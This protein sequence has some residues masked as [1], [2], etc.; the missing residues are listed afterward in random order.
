M[1]NEPIGFQ[2]KHNERKVTLEIEVI[3]NLVVVPVILNKILKM[4]MILDTGVQHT[5]LFDHVVSPLFYIDPHRTVTIMGLGEGE[6]IEANIATLVEMQVANVKAKNKGLLI[7]PPDTEQDVDKYLGIEVHG[8][9]GY[10][11]FKGLPIKIDYG[12]QRLTIYN[13]KFWK[14]KK[15]GYE[16]VPLTI[17][18]GK[19]Y[20]RLNLSDKNES[21]QD[22]EVLVDSGSAL[23]LSIN[24]YAD[25]KLTADEPQAQVSLGSGLIGNLEGS[26]SR[27]KELDIG[28]TTFKNVVAS[29]PN[30]ESSK[31]LQ[32]RKG[33]TGSLGAEVLS[34]YQCI[35]DYENAQLLLRK[36][37]RVRKPF[38]FNNTGLQ[39]MAD[40]KKHN[41]VLVEKVIAN[42]PADKAGLKEGDFLL[43]IQKLDKNDMTLRKALDTINS[44]R[45][46]KTL[47]LLVQRGEEVFH[48]R[49]VTEEII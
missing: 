38:R 17:R 42:S 23:G 6:E 2:F 20:M 39:I 28:I 22:C 1:A 30:K 40:E 35:Y 41:R 16:K 32:E 34:R 26:M 5:I 13:P 45:N 24:A 49:L 25:K 10:D 21:I 27:I 36:T 33:R 8:L 47:R 11:L 4:S 7:M 43:S 31:F 19:P 37:F 14:G 12:N 29:F 18:E 9:I 15:R 3:N 48:L 46:G 44:M